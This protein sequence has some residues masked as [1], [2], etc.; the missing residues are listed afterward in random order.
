MG[1][2]VLIFFDNFEFFNDRLIG[3]IVFNRCLCLR[4]YKMEVLGE[5]K[6]WFFG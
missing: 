5:E 2:S 1:V 6:T 4:R 3:S